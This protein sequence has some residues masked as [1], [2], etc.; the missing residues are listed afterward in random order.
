MTKQELDNA[1]NA[2]LNENEDKY[3]DVISSLSASIK[4]FYDEKEAKAKA[5]SKARITA[6]R[7]DLALAATDYVEAI[8]GGMSEKEYD[9][10]NENIL[11]AITDCEAELIKILPTIKKFNEE[12]ATKEMKRK[13]SDT[14]ILNDF[15]S[16]L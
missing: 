8:Y 16:R 12:K 14:E 2:Y 13:R 9:A 15:F 10:V 1:L 4:K 11:K 3:E 5:I 7:E 6:A